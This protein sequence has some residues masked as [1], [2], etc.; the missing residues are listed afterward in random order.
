MCRGWS[1]SCWDGWGWA[2]EPSTAGIA[3]PSGRDGGE[4]TG[5][6]RTLGN[7]APEHR[8][9]IRGIGPQVSRSHSLPLGTIPISLPAGLRAAGGGG[10]ETAF[11]DLLG[12]WTWLPAHRRRFV[13]SLP[14]PAGSEAPIPKQQSVAVGVRGMAALLQQTKG[15]AHSLCSRSVSLVYQAARARGYQ[16][17]G[18][19]AAGAPRGKGTPSALCEASCDLWSFNRSEKSHRTRSRLRWGWALSLWIPRRAKQ[20]PQQSARG[21]QVTWCNINH[22][23]KQR[24]SPGTRLA[25]IF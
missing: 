16:A 19:D 11:G 18:R 4:G 24:S 2:L 7:F 9:Q 5:L 3:S 25:F 14:G 12:S 22:G 8:A 10:K 15:F 20:L 21:C 6:T 13:S 1:L 23:D 17:A